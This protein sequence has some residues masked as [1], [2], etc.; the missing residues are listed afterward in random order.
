MVNEFT[1]DEGKSQAYGDLNW[2]AHAVPSNEEI[3]KKFTDIG[4]E[5]K[6]KFVDG[7]MGKTADDDEDNHDEMRMSSDEDHFDDDNVVREE[8]YEAARAG[9]ADL[10]GKCQIDLPYDFRRTS[11]TAPEDCS[12]PMLERQGDGIDYIFEF[13]ESAVCG[14]CGS[15]ARRSMSCTGGGKGMTFNDL[16]EKIPPIQEQNFTEDESVFT[17][18]VYS[19]KTHRTTSGR[20]KGRSTRSRTSSHRRKLSEGDPSKHRSR[21]SQLKEDYKAKSVANTASAF[22][23]ANVKH[24]AGDS[25]SVRTHDQEKVGLRS[26]SFKSGRGSAFENLSASKAL[27]TTTADST[28][29][30]TSAAAP[31]SST[32]TEL[33]ELCVLS[34]G[35][36]SSVSSFDEDGGHSWSHHTKHNR[37][38]SGSP[39][40]VLT[41]ITTNASHNKKSET[42]AK[43]TEWDQTIDTVVKGLKLLANFIH[44]LSSNL[45]GYGVA[46]P[47]NK[48]FCLMS[49]GFIFLFWPEAIEK[50]RVQIE[51]VEIPKKPAP[52]A[53]LL[54]L[55]TQGVSAREHAKE[56]C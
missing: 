40:S 44:S 26:L 7:V 24:S 6:A 15:K 28:A 27:T 38:L 29:F 50:D 55:V 20:S 22:I 42:T 48:F 47:V 18:S 14:D 31:A 39:N 1:K 34:L 56:E 23:R 25:E 53:S 54:T 46:A 52:P 49:V 45:Y 41:A 5:L 51:K 32:Y 37:K 19:T 12:T 4:N 9:C 36:G 10:Q 43:P 21:S 17:K 35:S 11:C 33:R 8:I 13:V 3:A 2:L 16:A 30:T